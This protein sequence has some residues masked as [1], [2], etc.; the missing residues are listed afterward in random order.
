MIEAGEI[1]PEL[2]A[3]DPVTDGHD[4]QLIPT[5]QTMAS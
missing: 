3:V 2:A 5:K 4:Q 1:Q